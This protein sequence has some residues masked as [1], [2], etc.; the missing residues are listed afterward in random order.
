M[1]KTN[2]LGPGALARSDARP[3]DMC[4]FNSRIRQHSFV[5][6]SHEIISTAILSR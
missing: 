3:S 2:S 1:F 6:F 4:R 5:E